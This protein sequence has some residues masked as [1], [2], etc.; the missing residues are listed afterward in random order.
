MGC[1]GLGSEHREDPRAA[2]YV[3]HRLVLEEVWIVYNRG[4]IRTRAHC[5]LQHLLVDTYMEG[6]SLEHTRTKPNMRRVPKCA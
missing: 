2:P 6:D 1:A 3:Q 4:T 5:V